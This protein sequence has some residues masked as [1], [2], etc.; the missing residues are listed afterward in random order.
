VHLHVGNEVE[1]CEFGPEIPLQAQE[2]GA[3]AGASVTHERQMTEV[4]L[5]F[6][7]QLLGQRA[8]CVIATRRAQVDPALII[9]IQ[10]LGEVERASCVVKR[11]RQ[12]MHRVVR[13]RFSDLDRLRRG[14]L[15]AEGT[16]RWAEGLHKAESITQVPLW[17]TR[18]I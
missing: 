3:L 4:S 7:V 12:D 17:V 6:A 18:W 13:F 14:L 10:G 8:T 2:L 1:A 15:G 9:L 5:L 16:R 11:S